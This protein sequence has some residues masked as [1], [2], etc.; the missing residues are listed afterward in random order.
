M[1]SFTAELPEDMQEI[2]KNYANM[3]NMPSIGVADNYMFP[4][5]QL[6]VAAAQHGDSGMLLSIQV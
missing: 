1:A 6:N 4:A 5:L 3:V 2:L